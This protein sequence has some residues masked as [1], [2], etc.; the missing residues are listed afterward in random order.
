MAAPVVLIPVDANTLTALA[1]RTALTGDVHWKIEIDPDGGGYHDYT[2]S[3]D[4]NQVS[5][6]ASSSVLQPAEATQASFSFRNSPKV[7]SEGDL[8]NCP[9]KISVQIGAG[10]F[11]QVF[12]GYVSP[13]GCSREKKHL[14]DDRISVTAY[15]P[16]KYRG[17][18]RRVKA[19]AYL[20]YKICDTAN[21]GTSL[22]HALA[23]AMG[24]SIPGDL[25]F[26]DIAYTKDYLGLDG[27]TT[28]WRELQDL[29]LHYGAFLG[30]RYDGDLR[31]LMWTAAEWA[32]ATPEY[33]F[34]STNV[35][36]WSAVG[37]EV[38]CNVARTEFSQYYALPAGSIVY[39]NYDQWDEVAQQNAIVVANGEYWP[40]GA[41]DLALARLNYQ[42]G[43][44]KFP[45]ATSIIT[46]TVGAV[47][48]G[49]DI[50]CSGGVVHVQSFNGSTAD[51]SQNLDSS[52]LIL[53]N[54]SGGSVTIRK[55][56]IRGTPLR[57]I[58]KLSVEHV[59][60]TVA[61]E[62]DRVEQEIPGKYGTTPAMA[63]VIA[64][65]WVDFGKEPR[66]EFDVLADF[67]P[68]LQCGAVVHLHPS[69]D[70]ELDCYV[71]G[72]THTS[73]GPHSRTR[74][75]VRLVE[76]VDWNATGAG[77]ASHEYVDN[78]YS[79]LDVYIVGSSTFSGECTK[80]C[81]GTADEVDINA[82]IQ[83]AKTLGLSTV[84]CVGGDFNLAAAVVGDDN[85]ILDVAAGAR[86]VKNGNFHAIECIGTSGTHKRKFSITG[87]G[88]ITRDAADTN[89]V[90]LVHLEYLDDFNVS[91]VT[92][93]DGHEHGLYIVNCTNGKLEASVKILDCAGT[94]LRN[95]AST[96]IL[97]AGITITG[98]GIGYECYPSLATDKIDY[99]NCESTNE[100][101][102]TG[103]T[104][105]VLTDC[106]WERSNTE[107]YSGTYSYKLSFEGNR[108]YSATLTD[109]ANTND[110]HGMTAGKTYLLSFY[111]MHDSTGSKPF[112]IY[113]TFAYYDSAAWTT[114]TAEYHN[115]SD[116]AF[117]HFSLIVKIPATATGAYIKLNGQSNPFAAGAIYFDDFVLYEFDDTDSGCQLVN[118]SISECTD[119]GVMIV[120]S[121]VQAQNNQITGNTNAG[122]VIAAGYR[123]IVSGNRCYN[124]GSD[125]G[126]A[127]DNGDNFL[128]SGI[129][130]QLS[131]NSFQ[132]PVTS[133]PSWGTSHVHVETLVNAAD[134]SGTGDTT[135][136]CTN[137]PTGATGIA[138]YAT[139]LSAT[140]AGRT[141]TIKD[142][143]GNTWMTIKNPT[144]AIAGTA[145]FE[146][147]LN[148]SKQFLYAV[149][150]ADVSAVSIFLRKYFS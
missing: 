19:T 80:K 122:L 23:A 135:V 20:N 57:E 21:T 101:M 29:A 39:K 144:T 74:T 113:T 134:P 106:T 129:D 97:A 94:G 120:N 141:L 138:G 105:P 56:E 115:S 114:K 125:T 11:F 78:N 31:L 15:D 26:Y 68:H 112:F 36:E 137:V 109:N 108:L 32:A 70:V 8:A 130:T 46:P 50:E 87:T 139:V 51:T 44:E 3:L 93:D 25:E 18:Q 2:A 66:K 59:D 5:I 143:A 123:N 118:S 145:T 53:H 111:A 132:S 126:L 49:S 148:S 104:E 33:T 24:L 6:Q 55:L 121:H 133:E 73:S 85:I 117:E 127:N 48:S 64:R 41:D 82:A 147:P 62:W 103:E 76:K 43:K 102:L 71:Q 79:P 77:T 14:V 99:G 86:F 136:T 61:N 7:W 95:I 142:S 81:D 110:L 75:R 88:T 149:D 119:I 63:K 52:E 45:I 1:P 35:H 140:T 38:T 10:A 65:R 128:D 9:V 146:V 60:A 150:N 89:H 42:F 131:G 98:C 16:A 27:K 22:A 12:F 96:V 92:I 83:A 91:G 107:K 116:V 34:D 54:A 124:N 40:G 69:A 58:K 4:S 13:Q 90:D 67:T 28:A 100:P 37:G 17:L 84:R 47:G 72:Y 30:F